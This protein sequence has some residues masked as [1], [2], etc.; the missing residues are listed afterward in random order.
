M[1]TFLEIDVLHV[2]E[3]ST[4]FESLLKKL[5]WIKKFRNYKNI[6]IK[7]VGNLGVNLRI[8]CKSELGICKKLELLIQS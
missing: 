3:I 6:K 8:S 5:Y 2:E 1:E 7:Y 4:N